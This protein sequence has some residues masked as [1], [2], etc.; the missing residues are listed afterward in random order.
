MEALHDKTEY[1]QHIREFMK[2]YY[3]EGYENLIE[4]IRLWETSIDK[5]LHFTYALGNCEKRGEDCFDLIVKE[6]RKEFFRK[7]CILWDRAEVAADGIFL[8]RIKKERVQLAYLE[9]FVCFDEIMQ[10][11]TSEEKAL[12]LEK[13]RKLI[14]EIIK[15]NIKITYWGQTLQ[16]QQDEI[17]EYYVK[18]PREWNYQW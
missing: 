3:G 17:R 2:A 5:N 10:E 1:E 11:G 18:G 13:N 15:Y 7:A 16:M 12:C 8:E 14:E 9:Q 6:K 4:Y